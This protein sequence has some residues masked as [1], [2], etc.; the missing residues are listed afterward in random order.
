MTIDELAP[1]IRT[2]K[3]EL[4]ESLLNGSYQPQPVREVEIPKEGN[5]VRQLGIPT[6]VDRL[7]QQAILQV[8]TPIF[9]P[10]F[11]NSPAAKEAMTN[12]WFR[13]LG[14]INLSK[15]FAEL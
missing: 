14:L 12:E 2:H 11:S 13:K 1:W 4:I 9:D 15:R 7:I 8:L 10:T 6:V 3:E 5:G